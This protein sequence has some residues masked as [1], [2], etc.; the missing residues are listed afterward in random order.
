[1]VRVSVNPELIGWACE[2]AGMSIDSLRR[3]FPNIE[4][5]QRGETKPTLKQ[6]ESFAKATYVPVGFMLL[7]KPPEQQAPIP[8]LR[9]FGNKPFKIPSPNLL[10]TVYICQRRQA[11]YYDYAKSAGEKRR[12]FVGSVRLDASVEKTAASIR[13]TLGFDLESQYRCSTWTEALVQFIGHAD[14]KGVLVMVSGVVGV[15]NK[16]KLDPEEFR[17]FAISDDLAPLVFING[18]DTKAAQIFTLAHE[19]AHLWLGESAISNVSPFS[20]P[21]E[22]IERWCN[23]VAAELL[24]PMQVLQTILPDNDPLE[25][26]QELAR[27][28][29]VSTLVILR[30]IFDAGRI[31][32]DEFQEAYRRELAKLQEYSRS[33]G[34]NFYLTQK[35]RVGR[36]FVRALIVSTLEG[37]TLYRD[38]FNMLGFKKEQT[39]IEF[40]RRMGVLD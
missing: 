33:S 12:E 6:L 18:A 29:K 17:G 4:Q 40:G 27:R 21:S 11:W 24:V 28:F 2:R 13:K 16:R 34:G 35:I 37:Q 31:S 38:A 8:D 23:A 36:R 26:A 9:T 25:D 14:D 5:W 39:F 32:R 1:M 3:K 22:G 20:I 7:T 19:L 15:N 30:R 10:D